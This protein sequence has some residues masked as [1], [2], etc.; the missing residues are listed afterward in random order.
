LP[1]LHRTRDDALGYGDTRDQRVS[2]VL[3]NK[4]AARGSV[5]DKLAFFNGLQSV[6]NTIHANTHL[7]EI[8]LDL[9]R[10]ICSLF[11]A[12]R[13]TIYVACDAGKSIVTK[14]KTGLNSYKD[15]KLPVTVQSVA[16]CVAFHKQV[17][18][19][20]DVYDAKAF[21]SYSPHLNFLR[22]VDTKTGYRTRR[23]SWRRSSMRKPGIWSASCS[24]STRC[25][26]SRSRR[27]WR[28]G[29]CSSLK[30]WRSHCASASGPCCPRADTMGWCETP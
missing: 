16:G 7:D 2:T 20:R 19:I 25:R 21:E 4:P 22:V 1:A 27:R 9:G 30:R 26:A 12:D 8:I 3:E 10:D 23:C 6:T 11:G 24:P 15:F 18:S 29:S 13:L 14:V 17:V 28:K 5:A